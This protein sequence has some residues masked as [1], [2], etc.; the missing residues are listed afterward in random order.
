MPR[1]FALATVALLVA[2]LVLA[3]SAPA[4]GLNIV[5]KYD[6]VSV[7]DEAGRLVGVFTDGDVRRHVMKG[8]D[9]ATLRLGD[10]MTTHPLSIPVGRLASEAAGILRER[11]VDEL[12][13]VDADGRPVGMVDIQDV[14]GTSI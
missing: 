2:A 8:A 14:L 7:V 13:V 3:G 5:V 9:F 11:S 12:P 4:Q 1:R 10:V 6:P